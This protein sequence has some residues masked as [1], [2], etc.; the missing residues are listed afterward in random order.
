VKR[1]PDAVF[2]EDA[3]RRYAI[4]RQR[5]QPLREVSARVRAAL[6]VCAALLAVALLG[7]ALYIVTLIR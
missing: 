2:R 6:W 1:E 3:L 5:E 4:A 7:I